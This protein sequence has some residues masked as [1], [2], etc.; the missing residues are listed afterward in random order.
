M[1]L[2]ELETGKRFVFEDTRTAL[3]LS[4]KD[5]GQYYPPKGTFELCGVAQYGWLRIRHEE[6]GKEMIV[7]AG[8]GLRYILPIL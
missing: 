6:T 4:G 5:Y 7:V 2:K 3:P 8:V 1:M